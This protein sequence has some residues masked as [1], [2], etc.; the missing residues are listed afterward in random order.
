MKKIAFIILLFPL[1]AIWKHAMSR[2]DITHYSM[3]IYFLILFWGILIVYSKKNRSKLIILATFSIILI[4]A[5][6]KNIPAYRPIKIE[7]NG[8]NNF[9]NS[10]IKFKS[11]NH[12][13]TGGTMSPS[14]AK[15]TQGSFSMRNP[16][17]CIQMSLK[18]AATSARWPH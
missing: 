1:F 18:S 11:F 5:N 14:E 16:K 2:Q 9:Y 8:I 4:Y 6:M 17:G 3:L 7:L 13:P 15:E 10:V 12:T